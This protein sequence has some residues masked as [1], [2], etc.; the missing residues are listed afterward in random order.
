MNINSLNFNNI[1]TK[2]IASNPSEVKQNDKLAFNPEHDKFTPSLPTE[3]EKTPIADSKKVFGMAGAYIG[4]KIGK[5]A[6]P[7]ALAAGAGVVAA[8]VLGPVGIIAAAAVGLTG[9]IA[10][11]KFSKA[12]SVAGGFAGAAI[13]LTSGAIA[14]KLGHS[15][16]ESRAEIAKDFSLKGLAKKIKN[17]LQHK[18]LLLT[19]S[20]KEI[21]KQTVQKGDIVITETDSPA[22]LFISGGQKALGVRSNW[23]HGAMV[24]EK[25]TVIEM[26][27]NGYN[28]KTI[29]E[30]LGRENHIMIL[31]PN[32]KDETSIHNTLAEMR[33]NE[34]AKY[35]FALSLG[36]D[37]KLYCTELIYKALKEGAPEI[38]VETRHELGRD[39][40][41]SQDLLHSKDMEVKYSTG[42][43]LL[44]NHVRKLS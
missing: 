43:D 22:N 1:H 17:Q 4:S 28:E 34:G 6:M 40:I 26:M 27:P 20:Q 11:E 21:F 12:G 5:I 38:N 10:T 9:G 13:G 7:V 18:D 37:D 30:V 14:D 44:F 3:R 42:S 35:D 15:P 32:Y 31:R 36:S 33:K 2:S 16:I 19:D 29:D 23:I 41:L 39:Y 25:G 8:T 24:T